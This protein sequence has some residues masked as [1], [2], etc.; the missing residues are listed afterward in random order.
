MINYEEKE[1]EKRLENIKLFR[2]SI[3]EKSTTIKIKNWAE[4]NNL[5]FEYVKYKILIDDVF[6]LNFIKEPSR[7]NLH[8]NLAA[9]EISSWHDV[10][11]RETFQVLPKSGDKAKVIDEKGDIVF[12]N[13]IDHSKNHS[14]TIDF[15]WESCDSEA[16]EI[17]YFFASHKY[18]KENG[19]AQDNQYN[20]IK[21]FMQ[22]AKLNDKKNQIFIAICDGEYYQKREPTNKGKTK[23][24]SLNDWY[25]IKN[26]SIA[27]TINK[28]RELLKNNF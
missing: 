21:N 2:S 14:K 27:I 4:K 19:G 23:L 8:E 28:L 15:E 11:I 9:E 6:S 25:F 7:Q 24:E 10:I 26:K 20:D 13:N 5:E 3:N 1:K 16:G 22:L 17:L 12:L 18:T